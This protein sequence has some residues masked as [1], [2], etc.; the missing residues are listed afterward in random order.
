M[1][2][3]D[4]ISAEELDRLDR[5]IEAAAL[6]ALIDLQAQ[7]DPEAMRQAVRDYLSGPLTDEERNIAAER[8]VTFPAGCSRLQALVSRHGEITTDVD[9]PAPG[10]DDSIIGHL[11]DVI[12]ALRQENELL[13]A[14]LAK[15]KDHE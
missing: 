12:D 4:T 5:R 8:G 3:R 10:S 1:K 11:C 9:G 15:P 6:A 7:K 14:Q 2:H 13:K